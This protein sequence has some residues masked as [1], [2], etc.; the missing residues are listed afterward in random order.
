MRRFFA[1]S[2]LAAM[3]FSTTEIPPA[4]AQT[5]DLVQKSVPAAGEEGSGLRVCGGIPGRI[6]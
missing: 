5:Q 1:Y 2:L 3:I 6:S 4:K